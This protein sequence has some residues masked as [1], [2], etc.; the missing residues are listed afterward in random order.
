M[1]HLGD[2]GDNL[3][4]KI[5]AQNKRLEETA[6]HQHQ[7]LQQQLKAKSR[8]SLSNFRQESENWLLAERTTITRAMEENH[9]IFKK[10]LSHQWI[11]ISLAAG[12]LCLGIL[13]GSWGLIGFSTMRITQKQTE[14]EQ[15]NQEIKQQEETLTQLQNETLGIKIGETSNGTFIT[16]PAD[17]QLTPGWMCQGQPCLKLE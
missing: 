3:K 6:E 15:I 13:G 17:Q 5:E 16:P 9:R 4:K 8:E 12:S 14:L 2:L 10:Y 7:E 11:W 1:E